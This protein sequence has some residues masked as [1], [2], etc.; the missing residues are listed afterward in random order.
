METIRHAGVTSLAV[1][2]A[3]LGAVFRLWDQLLT[4]VLP[5]LPF[6]S[7]YVGR[8]GGAVTRRAASAAQ[9]LG[10]ARNC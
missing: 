2:M 9:P 6:S 5:H 7:A 4:V 1:V 8:Q 3:I 10:E